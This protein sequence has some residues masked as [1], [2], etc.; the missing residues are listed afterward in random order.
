M[1]DEAAAYAIGRGSGFIHRQ[2]R[3][4]YKS[5]KDAAAS[6]IAVGGS[7]VRHWRQRLWLS[8]EAASFVE[9]GSGFI[10]LLEEAAASFV[11]GATSIGCQRR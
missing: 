5:L 10:R 1:E 4:R 8:L 2:R 11:G 3:R 9:G 7:I 6:F